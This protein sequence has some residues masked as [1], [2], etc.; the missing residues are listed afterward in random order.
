MV[1]VS[2]PDLPFAEGLKT[3]HVLA[4][5]SFHSSFVEGGI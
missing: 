4:H 5:D 3:V 2:G 1:G